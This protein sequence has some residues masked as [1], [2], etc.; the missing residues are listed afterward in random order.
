MNYDLAAVIPARLGSSRIKEKVFIDLGD[1]KSLL[2]RKIIQLSKCLPLDR[3][4]VNTESE[5]IADI[6][7][8]CNA[9]VHFRD[10][11]YSIN[12][13]KSFSELVV[14][15]VKKIETKHIA[16]TPFVVPF[17]DETCFARAF[18]NY[19]ELVINKKD[20]DSLISVVEVKEYFWNKNKPLNYQA[21]QNHTI[22]QDLP[23]WFKATNGIYMASKKTMLKQ[24]YVL[25]NKV[26]LNIEPNNTA[27]DIDTI[28]DVNMAKS[29]LN[30]LN[31]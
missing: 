11:I 13:L 21:N 17:L 12:H 4:I 24:K 3:I 20:Y 2:E 10:E 28:H 16:W 31:N 5:Q 25:G 22:S 18:A 23:Q 9:V 29:Y 6:A 1:G 19:K 8:K 27:I 30:I 7:R 26:F 15:V 14:H